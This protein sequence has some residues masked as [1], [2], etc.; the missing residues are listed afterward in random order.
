MKDKD[1]AI[2]LLITSALFYA[3]MSTFVKLSGDI[4][5]IEKSFFRNL[6]TCFAAY[7]LIRKNKDSLF[8]KKENRK[9]LFGRALLGTIGIV[10]NFYAIE[11][12]ILADANML[13]QLSPF[14][15]IIFSSIFLR[16][17]ITKPQLIILLVGFLGSL[18]IIRP[19]FNLTIIPSLIGVL[20]AICAG[21]S[22]AFIRYLG[23]RE[24]NATIVFFFAF[25]S[26]VSTFPFMLLNFKSFS[27]I[28]LIYL[29]MAGVTASIALFAITDAYKFAPA[30]EISIYSYTQVLFTALIGFIL[31]GEIPTKFSIIGYIIVISASISMFVYN[32]KLSK[33]SIS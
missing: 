27:F 26:A 4:P 25:F 29:L 1:K 11:H 18:F 24:K 9:F 31:F 6:V 19:S 5:A 10:A 33:E 20:S 23:N 13:N 16:E 2:L 14:F 3:L 30:K 15:V 8:G 12:L 28:Q 7:Y 22:Y 32:N 21:G 17:R